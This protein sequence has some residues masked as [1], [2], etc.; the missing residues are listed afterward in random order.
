MSYAAFVL[1]AVSLTACGG[2]SNETRKEI[3]ALRAELKGLKAELAKSK[4]S[5][6][7][8]GPE[9]ARDFGQ[10]LAAQ[11]KA[12]FERAKP[13]PALSKVANERLKQ[14]PG[15]TRPPAIQCA[16]DLCRMETTHQNEAAFLLFKSKAL[17]GLGASWQGAFTIVAVGREAGGALKA[18][19]YLEQEPARRF[20]PRA[21]DNFPCDCPG[22]APQKVAPPKG[23]TLA[24]P[25][26]QTG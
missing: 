18:T 7:E 17:F 15:T 1:A 3:D 21:N 25:G 20:I 6:Q 26:T 5:E 13:N 9:H 22:T 19:V 8:L 16:G 24:K 12:R 23:A 4:P 11:F 10:R 14:A 2:S